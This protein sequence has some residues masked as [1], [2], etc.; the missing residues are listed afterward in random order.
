MA[1][2]L[3]NHYTK[4]DK[5]VLLRDEDFINDAS[6]FLIDREGYDSSDLDEG[7]QVYD[8]FMEHFR[9]QN[10]NEVTALRD[11]T[12]A[13]DADD[14]S[15]A[16]FGR[17]MDTYD[18]MD[19]DL[20]LEAAGDYLGGVFTA[21]STYAGIFSF[22]AGKAG[23]LAAQQ[24]IKFGIRQALKT[25]A[26]R[27]GAVGAT[28]DA[29]SAG[30][31]VA[32]QE[33][34]RVES[35]LKEE[36]D[37]TQIGLATAIGGVAGG[38]LGTATGA[39]KAKVGFE[40]GEILKGTRKI[41]DDATEDAHS[42]VTKKV[43][44]DDRTTD[45]AN[46]FADTLFDDAIAI[47]EAELAEAGKTLTAK[48]KAALK[49]TIPD[50]LAKG[51]ILRGDIGEL[52]GKEIE[53][54]AAAAAKI[55]HLIPD[56]GEEL[57]K[58]KTE[59]FAS[60]FSRGITSGMIDPDDLG[61][62]L[63]DHNITI[64]QLG[65]LFAAELSRAGSI[66]GT[67]GAGVKK[68]TKDQAY[69]QNVKVMN[70]V[71]ET[72]RE[73]ALTETDKTVSMA[74]NLTGS[75]TTAARE[76]VDASH[77][78]KAG[79]FI[80]NVNKA[81]VGFMTIQPATTVRNTT[82]GYMRNYVYMMDNY[83]AGMANLAQGSLKK[84]MNP[85]DEMIKAEAERATKMGVAQLRTGFDSMLFKDLALGISSV[86][87]D[88]LFQIMRDPKFGQSKT[89]QRL[90]REM[91]DIGELTGT[92]GGLL[93]VSRKLNGLNTL[94]D[95]MFKRAIFSREID[96]AIRAKPIT[97]PQKDGSQLVINN[98]NEALKTG[99]FRAI[100]DD[101][102]SNAMEQAFDFTYQT[103][104]FQG[105]EGGFNV[106]ADTFIKF[107]QS[108]AG[109]TV[110][111]FPRYLVNQFRFAYEHAPVLGMLNIAG[112][113]NKPGKE[114]VQG[115]GFDS[116]RVA[117]NPETLGKQ[118]GGLAIL[119]TFLGLRSQF[120]DETTGAFEY[121]EPVIVD[122]DGSVSM[123][124][125]GDIYDA[126]AAIGPFSAYAVLADYLYK[127]NPY[128]WH[129]N[130]KVSQAKPFTSRE[131][132]EALAGGNIRAGTSLDILDGTVEILTNGVNAGDSELEIRDNVAK[133]FG[134]VANTFTVGAGAL[135]DIV[136]NLDPDYRKLPD[137]TDVNMWEYF[138]KQAGRSFP[139]AVGEGEGQ[140]RQLE[141]PTRSTG[142]S[143]VNPLLKQLTGF[144][145]VER[146][147]F[148]EEEL[149]RLK[150]DYQ[151][152]SPYR[153]KFDKPLSNE[154]RGT[155]G[156]FVE[157]KIRS[158]ISSDD[159]LLLPNDLEKRKRLKQEI[160]DFRTIARKIA[161][162]PENAP[163]KADFNRRRRAKYLNLPSV[164]RRILEARYKSV[165]P[166]LY[167][168]GIVEDGAFWMVDY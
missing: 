149:K 40:A 42:T 55:D 120:G 52:D 77:F 8:A 100:E 14:E 144:T 134:N 62:I 86:Q 79:N 24:G 91:G 130:D 2:P 152:L 139:V 35:G 136:A 118:L 83:G 162:N 34:A 23:A 17:L 92:E 141:S 13:Q 111:P 85:T 39:R 64:E 28:V 57:L 21:P 157:K 15:K 166:D 97:I 88:A 84:L 153:I 167:E 154:A 48:A 160:G 124:L 70:Q 108:T 36:V 102:F 105:R 125:S 138:L 63:R 60:R 165:F 41:I 75:I 50:D 148:V 93:G 59:R 25:G 142:I 99:N 68:L 18:K 116:V 117:V 143:R 101:Y 20:G 126:K 47:K 98:L 131:L 26:L 163:T 113:L 80:R 66:L 90:L 11:L 44:F 5:D 81:R 140:R 46:K 56:M 10:V 145:P 106:L 37:M 7:E 89:V 38:V 164:D 73:M 1:T 87:T 133:Y 78:T 151:E 32:L 132:I 29:A 49:Q 22:G 3:Y 74:R 65:P 107:G 27:G 109:S 96:K 137:N 161:L 122:S 158:F 51:K 114:G 95:N 155:M 67:F 9:Y 110:I 121:K 135:K 45:A 76:T 71:D 156:E 58:G 168:N 146:R 16:R 43:F 30:G 31:T 150:F 54:I 112:I 115:V 103:G 19:S 53:N 147:T 4:L 119:G 128:N 127:I 123:A 159:Y 94:S 61:T 6:Q 129:D 12:Y 82:N 104:G 69:K 72:L 33:S